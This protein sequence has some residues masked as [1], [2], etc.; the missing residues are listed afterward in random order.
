MSTDPPT[1]AESPEQGGYLRIATLLLAATLT[2]LSAPAFAQEVT[3]DFN[4]ATDFSRLKTYAWAS[5]GNLDD[6]L[7]HQRIVEA[8]DTQLAAKGFA[9]VGPGASPDVLVLY[10]V[11]FNRNLQITASGWGGYR[12]GPSPSGTARAEQLVIGTLAVGM[13][14]ARTGAVVWRGAAR[15]EVDI[16]ASPEKREK[17]INKAVEK[18]FKTYPRGE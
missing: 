4:E 17:N 3:Y 5:E 2:L 15:K 1:G 7:N 14:N 13:V 10:H 6:E 8:V 18:L 12:Y 9:K 11:T 16:D